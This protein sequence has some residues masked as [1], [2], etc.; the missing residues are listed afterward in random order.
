MQEEKLSR[1][2]PYVFYISGI[3]LAL[4]S[5]LIYF[6]VIEFEG[7]I[8]NDRLG[9]P[10]Q[11]PNTMGAVSAL[12]LMYAFMKVL[13]EKSETKDVWFSLAPT[14][15]FFL[16]LLLTESR[17]ALLVYLV[18]AYATLFFL[19]VKNQIKFIM[20]N[21][22]TVLSCF[23]CYF[24]I[25]QERT[26]ISFIVIMFFTILHIILVVKLLSRLDSIEFKHLAKIHIP[27]TI[28]VAILLLVLDLSFKG[29]IYK[30]L[31]NTLGVSF[32]H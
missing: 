17:G 5:S 15:L 32:S 14:E 12:F 6:R 29:S 22:T 3:L 9:G 18:V 21:V 4:V 20:L 19:P 23:L 31:H 30:L 7:A 10:F 1:I 2:S 28:T 24:L 8:V 13:D 16:N 11:Y 26:I 25:D 27:A